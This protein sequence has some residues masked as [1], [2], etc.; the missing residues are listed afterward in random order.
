[1]KSTPSFPPVA[2][3]IRDV[4]LAVDK[5][6][7]E[8][9]GSYR[10]LLEA[11]P[12]AMVVVDQAGE[13]VLLNL[14][15]ESQ[16]GYR[17]AELLGQQVTN[18]I[19][20]G[21]AARLMENDRRSAGDALAQQI[22]TGIELT[23]RR[24]DGSEFPIELMLSPLKIGAGRLVTAAIRDIS[25][26]KHA[27]KHLAELEGKR[28]LM[29]R[30]LCESEEQYRLLLDGVQ[31]H[32][33][34]M[35]N[36]QG[37]V[38]T[39]NAGAERIKG[40]K[41][42][43][44]IGRNFSCFFP[45]ED[46]ERDRPKEILRMTAANGRYEEQSMRV[47]QDGSQ[48]LANVTFS[49]LRDP[50]GNL[51][52]FSEFSHDLSESEE[53]GAKYRALLEA[54]PDAMVVVN[55]DGDIVLLNLQA[56]RQ[57]GYYRD[58][59][60]GRPVRT[61][62]PEGFAERLIAD[63]LRSEQDALAQQI[64]T[65]IELIGQRKDGS[66]FPI[67]IML[68]PLE[69]ADGYTVTVAIRDI[70]VR[71]DVEMHLARMARLKDEFVA[72]VSHELRTPLTS[73]SGSI[74]LL[75]ANVAGELPTPGPRLLSIAHTNCQRLVRLID[76]ILDIGKMNAGRV[77]FLFR[78]VEVRALVEQVIEANRE[79]A[80]GNRVRIRLADDSAVWE[81]RADKDRLAQ[82]I[83]NLLSN[84]IKFSPA[85]DEVVVTID[86]GPECVRISVRNH[87]PEIP[88]GFKPRMFERF[89]QADSATTRAK[90]G[91]GLGLSIA[92]QIVDRH[93]GEIGFAEAPGET[94]F[95]VDLPCWAHF[96]GMAIDR[97]APP[98]APR[99]LL[100]DNDP[101]MAVVVRTQLRQLGLATD[102]AY[103]AADAI[104][105][106]TVTQYDAVLVDLQLPDG[107]GVGVIQLLRELTQYAETPI[108][109]M[110]ADP[111]AGRD[112]VRI[113]ALNVFHW[114]NKPIDFDHLISALPK[115]SKRV[116]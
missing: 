101:D 19:P 93:G 110:A 84:A 6:L 46:V 37:G 115:H 108:I 23:G 111:G 13:I 18:I 30:A 91:T 54:A 63:D 90:G 21:F 53:A 85:D 47:R 42:E 12:D 77:A 69:R 11:A 99:I 62:I 61:I 79:Y 81:V 29:E 43:Q 98:D 27:E 45:Q 39:W 72:M 89:A 106:A 100:C 2:A 22:G 95:F 104:T 24:K 74:G 57:F 116:G 36:P 28:Q 112:D 16:F 97:D 55:R 71:K 9:G 17:R 60:L 64:G 7:A 51:R 4:G 31:D 94:T 73:I 41:A 5:R 14:Q 58:E 82:V 68:S 1:M 70:S 15:A 109:V 67:E 107:D 88:A 56:Q 35:M 32:A 105:F 113:V 80:Q 96:A 75:M 52:G 38:V 59:L 10:D 78:C 8:E 92:R 102:F 87:G 20:D 3:A 114:L 76:D 103:S 34:F 25:G 86:T 66:E 83:N 40:Y 48:F 44:I 50:V 26:R 49:A 65:G 33:I